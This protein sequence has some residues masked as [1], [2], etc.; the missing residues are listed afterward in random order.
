M[1]DIAAHIR[2]RDLYALIE[3]DDPTPIERADQSRG[4]NKA[5]RAQKIVMTLRASD[6]LAELETIVVGDMPH[7]ELMVSG[8][9]RPSDKISPGQKCTCILPIILLQ[10]DSPLLI[11]QA[12]DNLDNG[13][14]YDVLVKTLLLVK[15]NRQLLIV[16]HNA[17]VPVLG[18]AEQSF[19]LDLEDGAGII[20]KSGNV[21]AMHEW[22]EAKLDGGAE[23]FR[24]R[25]KRYGYRLER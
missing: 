12:E 8:K 10:S 14:I 7:V 16:T 23:A 18:D 19:L 22:M 15:E 13:Y 25:G 5:A 11:D 6:R 2:P 3:A 21:D 20:S 9:Y 24:K 1:N 17:N 4:G